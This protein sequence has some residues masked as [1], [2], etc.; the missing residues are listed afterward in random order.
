MGRAGKKS[1][2]KALAEARTM[3]PGRVVV[4]SGAFAVVSGGIVIADA[5]GKAA[6]VI[7]RTTDTK[8]LRGMLPTGDAPDYVHRVGDV[9]ELAPPEPLLHK[10][11]DCTANEEEGVHNRKKAGKSG[12][13]AR[14]HR[15]TY[16]RSLG[17]TWGSVR[18]RHDVYR[19][20]A[21]RGKFVSTNGREPEAAADHV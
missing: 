7:T 6:V 9:T 21:C 5:A 16:L 3:F 12:I 17:E 8:Q 19:C 1:E 2:A 18:T 14:V 10:C 4:A 15:L 20:R 13:P 11:P